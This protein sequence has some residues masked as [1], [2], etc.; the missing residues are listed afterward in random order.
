MQRYNKGR[1]YNDNTKVLFFCFCLE[2]DA[3]NLLGERR[4]NEVYHLWRLTGGDLEMT[5]RREGL[6]PKKPPIINLAK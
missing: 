5:L 4:I 3:V 6:I 2:H 1:L